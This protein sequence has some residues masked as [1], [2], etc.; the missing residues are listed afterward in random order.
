M[1]LACA[2]FALAAVTTEKSRMSSAKALTQL[3][4]H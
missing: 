1:V 2:A 3:T 4:D